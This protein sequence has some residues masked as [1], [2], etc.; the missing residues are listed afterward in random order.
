MSKSQ[1]NVAGSRG[2]E[3]PP[4]PAPRGVRSWIAAARRPLPFGWGLFA[5][6]VAAAL[7]ILLSGV[8]ALYDLDDGRLM[9]VLRFAASES[10]EARSAPPVRPTPAPPPIEVVERAEPP[11][12]QP[13]V[14][15]PTGELAATAEVDE[16]A[17]P[18]ATPPDKEP[19]PVG[20]H[21]VVEFSDAILNAIYVANA[22]I[23]AALSPAEQSMRIYSAA[24]LRQAPS[25]EPEVIRFDEPISAI[26]AKAVDEQPLLLVGL[27]GQPR[28]LV[29]DART[30]RILHEIPCP[31]P[32]L[33]IV[34]SD[35]AADA[36]AYCLIGAGQAI[37]QVDLR[38][39]KALNEF[40]EYISDV[41]ASPDGTFLYVQ[42]GQESTWGGLK[43]LPF[44]FRE[45]RGDYEPLTFAAQASG[46]LR[47]SGEH[48]TVTI[49]RNF[50]PPDMSERVGQTDFTPSAFFAGRPLVAGFEDAALC[51]A[52]TNTYRRVAAAALP[53]KLTLEPAPEEDSNG[54]D[55]PAWFR[56]VFHDAA[57]EQLI[58]VTPRRIF[59]VDLAKLNL[60]DEPSLAPRNE[61]PA[62]AYAGR[63]LNVEF[64][65]RGASPALSL[66]EHPPGVE[67]RGNVLAWT[68]TQEQ[69]GKRRVEVV[70]TVGNVSHKIVWTPQVEWDRVELDFRPHGFSISADGQR[71][72]AWG[73]ERERNA[74]PTALFRLAVVDVPG[75]RIL[76]VRKMTRVVNDAVLAH[77]GVIALS[78]NQLLKL[79]ADTLEPVDQATITRNGTKL[80]LVRNE[81]LAVVGGQHEPLRFKVV[82]L[83][84]VDEAS[85]DLDHRIHP[86]WE[87][88]R[89]AFGWCWDGMLWDDSLTKAQL[90][91]YPRDFRRRSQWPESVAAPNAPRPILVN[92]PA[93]HPF[94]FNGSQVANYG[95]PPS[96]DI[97][98][99]LS[100]VTKDGILRL[101]GRGL[102]DGV[103][104]FSEPIRPE[105]R[106]REIGGMPGD[107]SLALT[108]KGVVGVLAGREIRFGDLA[109]MLKRVEPP[110]YLEPRQSTFVLSSTEPT[111]VKYEA[112]DATSF[113][114]DSRDLSPEIR[115]G[116]WFH[117]ESPTG[118]FTL[119]VDAALDGLIEASMWMVRPQREQEKRRSNRALVADYIASVK[120]AFRQLTGRNPTGVVIPVQVMVTAEGPDFQTSSIFHDYLVE[121]PA[122][123]VEAALDAAD[124]RS[125]TVW[126]DRRD[127]P[128][129]QRDRSAPAN[130]AAQ[131]LDRLLAGAASAEEDGGPAAD[132]AAIE[133]AVRRGDERL[134]AAFAVDDSSD[135]T[136]IWTDSAGRKIEASLVQ[137]FGGQVVL[138]TTTGR[139]LTLDAEKLA[140]ADREYLAASAG[141]DA[142]GDGAKWRRFAAK[143]VA[144][145][146]RQFHT[147]HGCWPPQLLETADG[148]RLIGWRVWLLPQLGY[149]ELFALVHPREPWD[150]AAN[151]QLTRRMPLCF[152]F[153]PALTAQQKT[154]LLAITSPLSALRPNEAI[155]QDA[156][157]D[158]L[159]TVIAFA[160]VAADKAVIWTEPVDLPLAELADP[161]RALRRRQGRVHAGLL[162][163]AAAELPA[164]MP[165]SQWRAAV[166]INDD[167]R[168]AILAEVH[169]PPESP[170]GDSPLGGAPSH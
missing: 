66:G 147:E 47:A 43:P 117:A 116:K 24:G 133:E 102:N 69:Y 84:A 132:A 124:P 98:A 90:L 9:G 11:S 30:R 31:G 55:Q 115:Q 45:V 15:S 113:H 135:A 109:G 89:T 48:A 19:N 25:P 2:V 145:A 58:V 68:P 111:R 170:G 88:G 26:G 22:G 110:F 3:P 121:V 64:Q 63:E 127:R 129:P 74:E 112:A 40:G 79:E 87:V 23:V 12:E 164:S 141:P 56:K 155:A 29:M 150:S 10:Q 75:R 136:R 4:L 61:L 21:G 134:L 65:F 167:R 86:V 100:I 162:D 165:R 128:A 156:V 82:D 120:P 104:R 83:K 27:A 71:A 7:A 46:T 139:E 32:P 105:R 92:V 49:G 126:R 163:G 38:R 78:G 37:I 96:A 28:L 80:Q 114:I 81:D 168:S 151:S 16:A 131:V 54:Y 42:R 118:E 91:I 60:P 76:A 101:V 119:S 97:P 108:G 95:T 140:T 144:A 152:A 36:H 146:L 166:D 18:D 39:G 35:D 137:E 53:G 169:P 103:E 125:R 62:V 99:E 157:A 161:A 94:T 67:L 158:G 77:D 50:Y 51:V 5:I 33:K 107:Q 154:P 153:D 6:C 130:G 41:E 142:P 122:Q 1:T 34:A 143:R 44:S 72:L 73:P 123:D 52:S 93:W 8:T 149:P 20:V 160:E 14:L 57:N 138:R 106:L 17:T 159:D 70:A 85:A 13:P 148:K 59:G